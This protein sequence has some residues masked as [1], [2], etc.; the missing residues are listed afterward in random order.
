MQHSPIPPTVLKFGGA[1]L[2]DG[3]GV[4]RTCELVE[5]HGGARPIV[6]VSAARGVTQLL[7]ALWR[8]AAG[9]ALDG[10][11][12]ASAEDGEA[13]RRVRIRH[14]SLLSELGLD[15]EFLDRHLRE[16]SWVLAAIR[17][18]AAPSPADRDHVLSFG[19][20]MSARIV[21]ATLNRSG[22]PATPVDAYDLGLVSDSNHGRARPL[23]EQSER[24]KRT[25]AGVAG[26]PVVTG[27]VA[28]DEAGRLTTL[29][30][31]GSDLS[32]AL[33]AAAVG[34][35]EVQFWKS[36]P[37]VHT[38][39]PELVPDARLIRRL[40]YARATQFARSGASV[41]HPEAIEPL[42][43]AGIPARVVCFDA[44]DDE[45]TLI[46]GAA[47]AIPAR[48]LACTRDW[49]ELSGCPTDFDLPDGLR[50]RERLFAPWSDELGRALTRLAEPVSLVRDLAHIT[51]LRAPGEVARGAGVLAAAG[52]TPYAAAVDGAEAF[53]V[54]ASDLERAARILHTDL[55]ESTRDYA[56]D[57]ATRA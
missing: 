35:R 55:I 56:P 8:G 14:R 20:R 38:A 4:R 39:D 44:P 18:R 19:E 23:P 37:G 57:Q 24:V 25:L 43:A 32:A 21:A 46:E 2:A 54:R 41:L 31:N 27:F 12:G 33:V 52:L 50:V 49:V 15:A 6:V 7:E 16:L 1:A 47:D 36:V 11:A 28:I 48:G 17:G 51:V 22:V 30:R 45:G 10:A 9:L 29:G 34:A 13:A 40:D 26:V 3:R 5:R 42:A 53:V